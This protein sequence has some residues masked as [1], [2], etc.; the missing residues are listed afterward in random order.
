M[1]INTLILL[2][3]FLAGVARAQTLEELQAELQTI[4]TRI[5]AARQ[6]VMQSP[7]YQQLEE[8]RKKAEEAFKQALSAVPEAQA[9]DSQLKP[10]TDQRTTLEQKRKELA[11]Q[12]K[13]SEA[14]ELEHDI[15]ELSAQ[16]RSLL[17]QRGEVEAQN[18][19]MI[20]PRKKLLYDARQSEQAA[21]DGDDEGAALCRRRTDVLFKIHE[22]H[23][24]KTSAPASPLKTGKEA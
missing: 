8:S 12:G 2:M 1:K 21:L 10:L 9:I 7:K 19:E 17:K 6:R 23:K 13:T 3:M 16:I 22:Q 20:G 5:E 18:S 24:D 4:D 14:K 15:V 11:T